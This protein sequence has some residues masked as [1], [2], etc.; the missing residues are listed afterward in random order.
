MKVVLAH[1]YTHSPSPPLFSLSLPLPP[2]PSFSLTYLA[3]EES[4]T[5]ALIS[6]LL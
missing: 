4:L 2:P 3:A 1:K 6:P 5:M